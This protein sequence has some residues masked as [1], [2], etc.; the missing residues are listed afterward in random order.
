[1]QQG[2]DTIPEDSVYMTEYDR[3]GIHV[4]KEQAKEV[5]KCR[6]RDQKNEI[7]RRSMDDRHMKYLKYLERSALRRST[8]STPDKPNEWHTVRRQ[9]LGLSAVSRERV[10][11]PVDLEV[12]GN[13]HFSEEFLNFENSEEVLFSSVNEAMS[14]VAPKEY[15][16]IGRVT[17]NHA[18]VAQNDGQ[19]NVQ[20][21]CVSFSSVVDKLVN[22]DTH[23]DKLEVNHEKVKGRIGQRHKTS[24]VSTV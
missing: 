16:S 14:V 17:E 3:K 5:K 18:C 9:A 13:Q 2:L 4:G 12:D 11:T 7:K 19:E 15:A 24:K 8:D 6:L 10:V 22:D 1:M 21:N 23:V 20:R